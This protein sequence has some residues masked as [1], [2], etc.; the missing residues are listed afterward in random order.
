MKCIFIQAH[1]A[2]ILQEHHRPDIW[3]LWFLFCVCVSHF[4]SDDVCVDESQEGE[5]LQSS[6]ETRH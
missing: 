1:Q 4:V 2:S 3:F 6:V 5:E